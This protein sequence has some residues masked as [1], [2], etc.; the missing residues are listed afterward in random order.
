MISRRRVVLAGAV[1][2]ACGVESP[3]PKGEGWVRVSLDEHPELDAPG[4][5][6]R[7]TA[8]LIDAWL[9]HREDGSFAAAWSICTHG[10]CELAPEDEVLV[11][12]CHGSR[13]GLDGAVLQ[14]PAERPLKTMD[15]VQAGRAV[16]V[17]RRS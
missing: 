2:V 14:G 7:V 16:F 10:A 17:R 8:P 4:G 13:F 12:P 11:C 6:L 5:A 1:F 15:V 3:P 9:V